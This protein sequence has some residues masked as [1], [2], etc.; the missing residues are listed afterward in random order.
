MQIW[1]TIKRAITNLKTAFSLSFIMVTFV[2]A[3][4]SIQQFAA[5][6]R[7]PIQ[8]FNCLDFLQ[9]NYAPLFSYRK[10][11][12]I[13]VRFYHTAE[14]NSFLLRFDIGGY[15]LNGI[16]PQLFFLRRQITQKIVM[17]L[18]RHG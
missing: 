18:L 2:V 3:A 9:N 12:T 15:G 13:L 16:N 4:E 17:G 5:Q 14:R 10:F 1:T 7:E 8:I 6:N 11:N